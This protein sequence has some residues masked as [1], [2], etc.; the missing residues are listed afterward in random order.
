MAF[1]YRAICR[2]GD[3]LVPQKYQAFWNHPAG[4]KYI[5]FWAP[6]M[7]WGLS[8]AGLGNTLLPEERLSFNQSL[9]LVITGVIWARYS[10]VITPVN[11]N[12]MTVNI[13]M[14]LTNGINLIRAI[15]YRYKVTHGQTAKI[16][17]EG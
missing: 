1:V 4:P 9:S 11:Y 2:T 3:R 13:F 14:S 17:K 7:K 6:A 8:L 16:I 5:H 12:L 15:R 10:V